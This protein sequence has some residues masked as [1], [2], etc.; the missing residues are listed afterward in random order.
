M[1]ESQKQSLWIGNNDSIFDVKKIAKFV[2][3]MVA[4]FLFPFQSIADNNDNQGEDGFDDVGFEESDSFV[5]VDLD[6]TE[7]KAAEPEESWLHGYIK[8]EISRAYQKEDPYWNKIR[9]I[10]NLK[11][12]IPISESWRTKAE[13]NGFYDYAYTLENRDDFSDETLE[14]YESES[15]IRDFYIDGQITSWL[16]LTLGRQTIVWGESDY[17]QVTDL[18]NPRDNRELALVDIDDARIPVGALK[19]A[20]IASGWELD[21]VAIPEIRSNKN[22]V[23]GSDFDPYIAYRSQGIT[24]A[25]EE[26]PDSNSENVERLIRLYRAGM[27]GDMALTCAEVYDDSPY[28]DL[29]WSFQNSMLDIQL[30]PKHQRIQSCGLAVNLAT[31]AFIWKVEAATIKKR[32][33]MRNDLAEELAR[34]SVNPSY[35]AQSWSEKDINQFV[36]GFDYSGLTNFTITLELFAEQIEDYEEN[37]LAKENSGM[38]ALQ[39]S[40]STWNE[41]LDI[42]FLLLA[43]SDNDG[44][45]FR[46]NIDYDV[47]D[48]LNVGL[49]LIMYETE[50]EKA[51][52]YQYRK[53]DRAFAS[54]KYSF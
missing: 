36:L 42:G 9:T 15:E 3:I 6:L 50:N 48:A 45:I 49:G 26:I 44:S 16:Q 20:F 32:A 29:D 21:L 38:L 8:E 2:F 23:N 35:D 14:A 10:L 54:I 47:M 25:D 40:Y 37:L 12:E 7:I 31:G 33:E 22:P 1:S 4:V 39:T 28:L 5:E 18:V 41:T 53:Q 24:I 52:L 17:F 43:L 27:G 46:I 19:I 11:L 34:L 51:Q 30:I 13:W